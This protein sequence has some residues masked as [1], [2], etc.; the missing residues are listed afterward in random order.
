LRLHD[1]FLL[2]AGRGESSARSC[3]IVCHSSQQTFTEI[4]AQTDAAFA[5]PGI[6]AQRDQGPFRRS[7]IAFGQRAQKPNIRRGSNGAST[8]R[9]D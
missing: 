1:L 9:P 3:L 5:P 2:C 7:R 8:L 4:A 6:V